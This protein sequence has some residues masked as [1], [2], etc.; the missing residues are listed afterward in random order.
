MNIQPH[1]TFLSLSFSLTSDENRFSK[2]CSMAIASRAA[3]TVP[4]AGISRV[5]LVPGVGYFETGAA[6]R[7]ETD[8]DNKREKRWR[9]AFR[10]EKTKRRVDLGP[11]VAKKQQRP[12]AGHAFLPVY[13]SP[14]TNVARFPAP[15]ALFSLSPSTILLLLRTQMVPAGVC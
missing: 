13:L 5:L 7:E 1:A 11:S 15:L 10:T 6:A 12:R 9:S 8:G 14:N 2:S 4:N 3:S